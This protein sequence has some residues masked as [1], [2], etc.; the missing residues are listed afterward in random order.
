M[1]FIPPSP[2][3]TSA[4]PKAPLPPPPRNLTDTKPYPD[5]RPPELTCTLDTLNVRLSVHPVLMPTLLPGQEVAAGATG[6]GNTL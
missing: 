3:S 4:T 5:P 1:L 2:A 6:A